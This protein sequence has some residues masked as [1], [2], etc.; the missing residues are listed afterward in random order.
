MRSKGTLLRA[1]IDDDVTM[2]NVRDSWQK[3]TDMS[4]AEQM[5]ATRVNIFL[6]NVLEQLKTGATTQIERVFQYCRKD[7][8]LHELGSMSRTVKCIVELY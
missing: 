3:V 7:I 5:D 2:E 4:Q 8:V 6:L 1:S